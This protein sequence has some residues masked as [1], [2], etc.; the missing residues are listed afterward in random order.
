VQWMSH[1]AFNSTQH[2]TLLM[3]SFHEIF[4]QNLYTATA[5]R[6]LENLQKIQENPEEFSRR[7]LWELLQNACDA[8]PKGRSLDF[9][10]DYQWP[11]LKI[12]HNG[13][14]FSIMELANLCIPDSSKD[15]EEVTVGQYGTG[16]LSTHALSSEI[17]VTGPLIESESK[18][19]K[20]FRLVLDR[21]ACKS[22]TQLA[23]AIVK[24]TSDLEKSFKTSP[25]FKLMSTTYSYDL[26]KPLNLM[27]TA[28]KTQNAIEETMKKN[29][30]DFCR[31]LPYAAL[32]RGTMINCVIVRV[33]GNE[34]KY[35][36]E[37]EHNNFR[38][39]LNGQ[40]HQTLLYKKYDS[41]FKKNSSTTS[42]VAIPIVEGKNGSI[43]VQ[44]MEHIPKLF[45]AFPLLGTEKIL[46]PAIVHS[47]LFAP[48]EKRDG[49]NRR[50]NE[51]MWTSTI[52]PRLKNFF[53]SLPDLKHSYNFIG[54]DPNVRDWTFDSIVSNI[55][56]SCEIV[57]T[58]KRTT[59]SLSTGYIPASARLHELL[60]KWYTFPVLKEL[61]EWK[62]RCSIFTGWRYGNFIKGVNNDTLIHKISTERQ[63]CTDVEWYKD[64]LRYLF[65]NCYCYGDKLI[66]NCSDSMV[67]LNSRLQILSADDRNDEF[68]AAHHIITGMDKNEQLLD[69]SLH[70]LASE[71]PMWREIR[72]I[73][74]KDLCE[75]IQQAV[76]TKWNLISTKLDGN[77]H[78]M[79]EAFRS[80]MMLMR[81]DKSLCDRLSSLKT[82]EAD[83][84][85]K[86][87]P[88]NKQKEVLEVMHDPR[89]M[90]FFK[91]TRE[92]NQ[93]HK[94]VAMVEDPEMMEAVKGLS[95]EEIK[96][97]LTSVQQMDGEMSDE[98][99]ANVV[100]QLRSPRVSRGVRSNG[101]SS[102]TP[103]VSRLVHAM[104]NASLTDE[105]GRRGEQM[106]YDDLCEK[107]GGNNVTWSA[108]NGEGRF[109]IV[110][111]TSTG[112]KIYVEVKATQTSRDES[113]HLYIHAPQW[114]FMREISSNRSSGDEF[115]MARCFSVMG[116]GE[117]DYVCMEHRF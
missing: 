98:T 61:D 78:E 85:F 63:C 41:P 105:I 102:S 82:H 35:T 86:L 1:S 65:D 42:V 103:I 110:V 53:H 4:A 55:L 72:E 49:I 48:T 62:K 73:T 3:P 96:E 21:S 12:S 84:M 108:R 51:S 17:T 18:M 100:T 37:D 99:L 74:L 10:I 45:C 77:N 109:D 59:E 79:K 75:D 91:K 38:M 44:P 88:L 15:E 106:V 89:C 27:P 52:V 68:L 39:L 13:K 30:E 92:T 115:W 33:K 113:S 9:T 80:L 40:H 114:R 32:F 25:R 16:F 116:Q 50:R 76:L 46:C 64:C 81:N 31:M 71:L 5:K 104:R 97:L 6:V 36:F 34:Q 11:V 57:H 93:M 83:I 60:S 66:K 23:K 70:S 67:S 87:F 20:S 28:M 26:S 111:N 101:R 47:S 95:V 90:D 54:E 117:I 22:K 94:F 19:S 8:M 58:P 14:A 56:K 29:L 2:T 24:Y 69:P 107:C 112:H 7:I 43:Q